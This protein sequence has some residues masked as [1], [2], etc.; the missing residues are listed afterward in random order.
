VHAIHVQKASEKCNHR[1][2]KGEDPSCKSKV[3][4]PQ[5]WPCLGRAMW[6]WLGVIILSDSFKDT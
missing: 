2:K 3:L 1:S 4:T 6:E 5:S